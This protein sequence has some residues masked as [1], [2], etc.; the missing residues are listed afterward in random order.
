MIGVRNGD[1]TIGRLQDRS[2]SA[3]PLDVLIGIAADSQSKARV[4][5][6]AISGEIASHFVRR[7]L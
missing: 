7:L 2:L 1:E 4:A 6:V 3:N 5:M